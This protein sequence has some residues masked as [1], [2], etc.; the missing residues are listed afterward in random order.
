MKLEVAYV[1]LCVGEKAEILS[2]KLS[3]GTI[4]FKDCFCTSRKS[5]IEGGGWAY[6]TH[7]HA[8]GTCLGWAVEWPWLSLLTLLA[9]TGVEITLLPLEEHHFWYCRQ[10]G[11]A[12]H[13]LV[14][15]S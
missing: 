7:A 3:V 11:Q 5:G 15:V 14:G 13:W 12:E 6:Q 8:H 4:Q 9:Q 2:Q 1:S 10:F